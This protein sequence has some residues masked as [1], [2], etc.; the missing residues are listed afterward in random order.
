MAKQDF[1]GLSFWEFTVVGDREFALVWYLGTQGFC[2]FFS[3][4]ILKRVKEIVRPGP[5]FLP[6]V[7]SHLDPRDCPPIVITE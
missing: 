6:E 7:S 4:G 3:E 1:V 5:G 2:Q